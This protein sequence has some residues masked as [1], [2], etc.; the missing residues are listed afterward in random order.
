MFLDSRVFGPEFSPL[1]LSSKVGSRFPSW[2]SLLL[3]FS[4][5]PSIRPPRPPR[6]SRLVLL[7]PK[8]RNLKNERLYPPSKFFVCRR[9]PQIWR[10]PRPFEFSIPNFVHGLFDFPIFFQCIQNAFRFQGEKHRGI[11]FTNFLR[12]SLAQNFS[13]DM[14]ELKSYDLLIFLWRRIS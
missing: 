14:C 4:S 9:R 1:P 12:L 5:S 2:P 7:S 8:N 3:F 11:G 6:V 13:L 10:L